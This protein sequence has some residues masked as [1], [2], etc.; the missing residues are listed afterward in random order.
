MA[1]ES[2]GLLEALRDPEGDRRITDHWPA[3]LRAIDTK[4]LARGRFVLDRFALRVQ[5][6]SVGLELA[7]AVRS[8]GAVARQQQARNSALE[9]R[10]AEA[11]QSRTAEHALVAAISDNGGVD[12]RSDGQLVVVVL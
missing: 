7:K 10:K 1:G 12:P 11:N 3:A 6:R 2:V 5:P 4:R 9:G 8:I